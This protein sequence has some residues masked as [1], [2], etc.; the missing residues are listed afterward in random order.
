MGLVMR[1]SSIRYII[2]ERYK[3]GCGYTL[4]AILKIC[5]RDY[6]VVIAG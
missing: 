3:D 6:K 4:K 1:K 5:E 2:R